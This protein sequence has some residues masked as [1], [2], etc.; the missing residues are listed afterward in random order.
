LIDI[1]E[2]YRGL[3]A[4]EKTAEGFCMPD[5]ATVPQAAQAIA[6]YFDEHAPA[7]SFSARILAYMALRHAFPCPGRT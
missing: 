1:N 2:I 4:L 7:L 6:R 3:G 5:T